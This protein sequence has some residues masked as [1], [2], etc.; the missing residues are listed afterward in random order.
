MT[1]GT[2]ICELRLPAERRHH[3]TDDDQGHCLIS[4]APKSASKEKRKILTMAPIQVI[5]KLSASGRPKD[6]GASVVSE[7]RAVATGSG[8]PAGFPGFLLIRSLPLSVLTRHRV[9]D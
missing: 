9:F 5:V 3:I 8:S 4:Y 6:F 1:G 7:P 2:V